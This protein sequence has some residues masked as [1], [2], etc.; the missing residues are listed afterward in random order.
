MPMKCSLQP[1]KESSMKKPEM[2]HTILKS[3][4]KVSL[5]IKAV[6]VLLAMKTPDCDP[7]LDDNMMIRF[8]R[9]YKDFFG[10]NI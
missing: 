7:S 4:R 10:I 9:K 1:L 6:P 5:Y 2:M 3:H 8:N